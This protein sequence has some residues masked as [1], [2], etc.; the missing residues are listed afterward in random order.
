MAGVYGLGAAPVNSQS[1]PGI[2]DDLPNDGSGWSQWCCQKNGAPWIPSI[3]PS[4][5]GIYLG[6]F[7]DISLT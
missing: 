7:C 1:D 3:Y 4:H 2:G 5:V 6:K